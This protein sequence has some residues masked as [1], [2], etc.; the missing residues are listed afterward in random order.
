MGKILDQ[1]VPSVNPLPTQAGYWCQ[2]C[3]GET[4][5]VPL[6]WS[7]NLFGLHIKHFKWK[8]IEASIR[9]HRSCCDVVRSYT[10]KYIQFWNPLLELKSCT[11]WNCRVGMRTGFSEKQRSS[12]CLW[13]CI[14]CSITSGLTPCWQSL[15][16]EAGWSVIP[17]PGTWETERT[18]GRVNPQTCTYSHMQ[19]QEM[20]LIISIKWLIRFTS[21]FVRWYLKQTRVWPFCGMI[22]EQ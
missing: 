5:T 21:N 14:R 8:K 18:L 4:G 12:S 9:Q 16:M 15:Q 13:A 17:Q 3:Y 6:S 1:P 7:F 19:K 22:R 11:K 20:V 10:S 2:Q